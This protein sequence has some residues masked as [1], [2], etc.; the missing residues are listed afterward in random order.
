[1]ST[2]KKNMGREFSTLEAT[3]VYENEYLFWINKELDKT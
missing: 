2:Q 1:M 3:K